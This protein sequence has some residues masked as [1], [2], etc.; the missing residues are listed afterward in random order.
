MKISKEEL[1]SKLEAARTA[2][3][4]YDPDDNISLI[5]DTVYDMWQDEIIDTEEAI[6]LLVEDGF[7]FE[8]ATDDV[9]EWER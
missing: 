1:D 7:T 8:N 3:N 5:Y 4:G 6:Q 9:L 2:P